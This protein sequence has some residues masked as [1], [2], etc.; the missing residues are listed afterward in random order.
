MTAKSLLK[1]FYEDGIIQKQ[2]SGMKRYVY[3]CPNEK[4]LENYLNIQNDILSIENYIKEFGSDSSDGESSLV[5]TRST[6]TFRNKSLQGFFIKSIDTE[7]TISGEIL[8]NVSEGT[9]L[10]VYQPDRL[11]ISNEALIVG[12]E[13]PECF[14]KFEKLAPLF[15]KKE[16]I[17]IMRYLSQNPNK[18][19]QTVPNHYLHFGDFDPAG[20]KIYISEYRTRLPESR[21]H[22]FLP[23][24]IEQLVQQYGLASLYDKQIHLLNNLDIQLYPEVQ[25]LVRILKKHRKGLEQERLLSL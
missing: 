9:A 14:V 21:C 1:R 17:V 12:I 15:P 20:I 23:P 6:K 4:A 11:K 13:N 8:K 16:L 22:Y 7:I 24:G 3:F 5:S 2:V 25:D 18:W 10:F 19:L